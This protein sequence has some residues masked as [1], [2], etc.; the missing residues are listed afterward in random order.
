VTEMQSRSGTSELTGADIDRLT[1]FTKA[2][3]EKLP[4]SPI[5]V[6]VLAGEEPVHI[7]IEDVEHLVAS[8]KAQLPVSELV[9][10]GET[11]LGILR[12]RM[13]SWTGAE[14]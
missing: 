12:D 9:K 7:Y 3:R 10:M 13:T 1:R 6:G 14:L 11:P 2:Y 5:L 4:N 8:A